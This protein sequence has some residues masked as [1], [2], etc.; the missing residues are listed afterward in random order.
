[1]A[2]D[3]PSCY[4]LLLVEQISLPLEEELR[5]SSLLGGHL[6]CRREAW[7][8]RLT[9]SARDAS[10]DL[11]LPVVA[12]EPEKAVRLLGWLGEHRVQAPTLAVLPMEVPAEI[13]AAASEVVDDFI[14]WPFRPC[15]LNQ[16]LMRILGERRADLEAVRSRLN[17]ELGLTSLV[18]ADPSFLRSIQMIP[19]VA[20]SEGTVLITGETGTGKELFA[21]AVH[22]LSRRCTFPF[23]PVDC[24]GFPELLVENELFGHARGAFTDAR[25][26]QKGLAALAQ[27]GTLFLDEI[28]ALSLSSQAKLLRFLED[29]V[30][31]PLGAER[32]ERADVRV[33][34]ATNRDL[35]AQVQERRFRADLFF[36]L[37]VFRL[38]IAP[39]RERRGDIALL[40]HHFVETLSADLGQGRRA[41]SS[42]ALGCLTQYDWPGNV[43][44]LRNEIQRALTF[45][46]GTQILP[47]HIC[48]P[49][50]PAE[51]QEAPASFREARA[52]AL[53]DFERDYLEEILVKHHGNITRAAREA[54][55]E[56]RAF[57]RLIKKHGIGRQPH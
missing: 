42:A 31:K 5:A 53:W 30:Y 11:V 1:M 36:R 28:D 23:V 21:R 14:L 39:L 17:L 40:A 37:N 3:D 29:H 43:R 16:R 51:S 4:R 38:R 46:E 49:V 22:H 2:M 50:I 7:S 27:R 24:G 52:R 55:K 33:V 35:E 41:L 34:A 8:E 20:A 10:V 12:R 54:G 19:R 25:S 15:E 6:L 48:L 18:G 9:I 32:F 56:R 47:C 57:G 26:D 13:L 45:A 44:E